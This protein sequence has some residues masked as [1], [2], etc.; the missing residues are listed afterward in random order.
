MT[1][2]AIPDDAGV[3]VMVESGDAERENEQAAEE[4]RDRRPSAPFCSEYRELPHRKAR[5]FPGPQK[6][7]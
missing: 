2:G 5:F 4:Q 1:N 6:A 7:T 3:L